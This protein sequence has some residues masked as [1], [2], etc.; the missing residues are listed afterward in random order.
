M[1][2]N[3][4]IADEL[5]RMNHGGAWH[6]PAIRETLEGVSATEAAARPING[7]HSIWEIVL[8]M[9]AWAEE[10]GR[11]LAENARSLTGEADWPIPRDETLEAWESARSRLI[12]AHKRLRAAIREFPHSR[13]QDTVGGTDDDG[14]PDSFY[15]MLHGLAQHDAYH[16]GQIAILKRALA[17]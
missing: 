3:E 7:A 10:V 14:A 4:R 1:L 8:H 16:T 15:V 17:S 9:T 12:D 2:E 13:L 11:R 5:D 6:G